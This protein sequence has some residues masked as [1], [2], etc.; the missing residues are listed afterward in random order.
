MKIENDFRKKIQTNVRE[1]AVLV[2]VENKDMSV[3]RV[4]KIMRRFGLGKSMLNQTCQ[5]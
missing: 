3:K 2:E 1:R 4:R 5:R